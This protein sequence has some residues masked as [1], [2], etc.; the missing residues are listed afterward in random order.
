MFSD[1]TRVIIALIFTSMFVFSVIKVMKKITDTE[2]QNRT[3]FVRW[4]RFC[5]KLDNKEMLYYPF[6]VRQKM[7]KK[8][9]Y[10]NLPMML[11]ILKPFYALGKIPGSLSWMIFKLLWAILIVYVALS[12]AHHFP[13][14]AKILAVALTFRIFASDMTH[15]NVNL[16]IGGLVVLS[17]WFF[18]N[19]KDALCG[20]TIGLA[21]V[22]K[23]TPLLFIPYF[24][25]KKQWRIAIF[26]IVGILLFL[27]VL[28]AMFIGWDYNNDLIVG[29]GEQ[30]LYPFISG[31]V[32]QMQV[33]H[34]N[35]SLT[36]IFHRLFSDCVAITRGAH[37]INIISLAPSQVALLI[38]IAC[39]ALFVAIWVCAQTNEDR[40]HIG[41]LGEFAMVFLA[42]LLMSERTWKHHQI[43]LILPHIFLLSHLFSIKNATKT[44]VFYLLIVS[45]F[46]HTFSGSFLWGKHYSAFLQAYGAHFWS[47]IMLFSACAHITRSNRKQ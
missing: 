11:L 15:G 41:Y 9:E 40:S 39:I 8:D 28:P 45:C 27:F 26:S 12:Y 44:T 43:L 10:P 32:L 35:Q 23:V 4:S 42:M 16:F 17:L 3:A 1:K 24:I 46:F 33:N 22:L 5:K 13:N 31:E 25:V 38:K 18:Q 36:G 30:M 47:N 20:L 29:W 34:N 7:E 2:K 21:S 37:K 19:H 14:W 6:D